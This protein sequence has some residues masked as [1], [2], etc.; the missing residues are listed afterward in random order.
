M[1]T[2]AFNFRKIRKG[3]V[4]LKIWDV[5]GAFS[6]PIPQGARELNY[7]VGGQDN[8]SSARCGSGIAMGSMLLCESPLRR[9]GKYAAG[10]HRAEFSDT[11]LQYTD[12]W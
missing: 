12:M 3:N 6:I 7:T 5:A 9:A 10:V 4:T 8:R 2:V 11:L 1:P